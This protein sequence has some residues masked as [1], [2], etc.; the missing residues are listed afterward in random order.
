VAIPHIRGFVN[1]REVERQV[2]TGCQ[3][4]SQPTEHPR[5]GDAASGLQWG[6]HTIKHRQ[7]RGTLQLRQSRFQ[8]QAPDIAIRPT[9]VSNCQASTTSSH[10]F[11]KK[12]RLNRCASTSLAASAKRGWITSRKAMCV[13]PKC[14]S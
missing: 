5:V 3:L 13:R 12:C 9:Q 8:A 14:N 1:H 11:S 6:A 2:S 10:S 7:E 4:R